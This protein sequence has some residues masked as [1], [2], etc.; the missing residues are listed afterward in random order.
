MIDTI[1]GTSRY[2]VSISPTP[3][4]FVIYETNLSLDELAV[5]P[6]TNLAIALE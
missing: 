4:I 1:F 6:A 5:Q 3:L 2:A